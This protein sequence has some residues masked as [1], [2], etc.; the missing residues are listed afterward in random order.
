MKRQRGRGRKPGGHH[1]PNRAMESNGPDVKVRGPAIV[2]YEKYMQYARDAQSAGD[3]IQAE[4][5]QQHAEH[6]FRLMRAQQP[7]QPLPT[8]QH[9]RFSPD[10]DYESEDE[11][12]ES[13][14]GES[15][16]SAQAFEPGEQPA[17]VRNDA[18]NQTFETEGQGQG[19]R[20]SRR[21]GRRNRFRPEGERDHRSESFERRDNREG[22]PRERRDTREGE[23]REARE[24]REPR[25][26]RDD[27]DGGRRERFERKDRSERRGRGREEEAPSEGFAGQAPAF[28][29]S[30]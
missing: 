15:Q 27:Y 30:D 26:P 28:L 4:N 18:E 19:F 7:S 13:A 23:P 25:E 5:Y 17:E 8:Q 9:D 16:G 10:Y 1:Q 3:R 22:E 2:I 24:A 12:S 21:R 29:G 14:E 20:G 11:G 6:Y